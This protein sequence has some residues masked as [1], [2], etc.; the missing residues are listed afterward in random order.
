MYVASASADLTPQGRAIQEAAVRFGD[1]ETLPFTPCKKGF[2]P[3]VNGQ[4]MHACPL[5]N[6]SRQRRLRKEGFV[7]RKGEVNQDEYW[8]ILNGIN[9]SIADNQKEN[10]AD[11]P[12]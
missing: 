1:G 7:F 5:H 12:N 4:R 3:I 6:R 10:G 11:Q 9:A 2:I 8:P